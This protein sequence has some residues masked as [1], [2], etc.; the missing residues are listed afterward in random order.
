MENN[1]FQRVMTTTTVQTFTFPWK[2]LKKNNLPPGHK[3]ENITVQ[4]REKKDAHFP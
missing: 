3:I 4:F 1:W 2:E